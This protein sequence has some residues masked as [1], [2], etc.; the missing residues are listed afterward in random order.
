MG[1]VSR[2]EM[3]RWA[4]VGVAALAVPGVLRGG[5]MKVPGDPEPVGDFGFETNSVK[6][7]DV[8]DGVRVLQ[9]PGGNVTVVVGQDGAAAM[10]DSGVPP[11]GAQPLPVRSVNVSTAPS[12][13]LPGRP[14]R[15]PVGPSDPVARLKRS[16]TNK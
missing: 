13:L 5:Q 12:S 6:S 3:M 1:S 2:R 7:V 15:S 11:R 16:A 9:G 4:G 10:V 14:L 8:A